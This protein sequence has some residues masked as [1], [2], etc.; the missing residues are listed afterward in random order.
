MIKT[1]YSV[2]ATVQLTLTEG[3][4][5][6]L[7]A[8]AGYG[9]P[10]ALAALEAF[11]VKCGKHYMEPFEKD[12]LNLLDKV[13]NQVPEFL[14]RCDQAREAFCPELKKARLNAEQ[15]RE[16]LTPSPPLNPGLSPARR[17]KSYEHYQ[18]APLPYGF[19]LKNGDT[20]G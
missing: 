19:D 6:A 9:P 11:Y 7:D 4:A 12:F 15:A 5:R 8:L 17:F 10:A 20:P 16:V 13:R 1:I 3:E 2:N 14:Q 18:R